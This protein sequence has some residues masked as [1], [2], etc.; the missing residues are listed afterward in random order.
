MDKPHGMP[1]ESIDGQ[2]QI[3]VTEPLNRDADVLLRW[4]QTSLFGGCPTLDPRRIDGR[5][6]FLFQKCSDE[7]TVKYSLLTAVSNYK[8]VKLLMNGKEIPI[9]PHVKDVNR[10]SGGLLGDAAKMGRSGGMC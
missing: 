1:K 2:W 9:E 6:F 5:D 7:W 3:W 8:F 4:P 10:P